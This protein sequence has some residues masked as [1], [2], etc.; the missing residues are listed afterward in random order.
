MDFLKAMLGAN[1]AKGLGSQKCR[2]VELS[3]ISGTGM[4]GLFMPQGQSA[5]PPGV[6]LIHD[7]PDGRVMHRPGPESEVEPV[8]KTDHGLIQHRQGFMARD[9]GRD[10]R[11]NLFCQTVLP[12]PEQRLPV[13]GH[14][15]EVVIERAPRQ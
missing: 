10:L 3:Q 12:R 14:P 6:H 2:V 13:L 4:A 9:S 7:F 5:Y 15:G 1:P 11:N 8:V